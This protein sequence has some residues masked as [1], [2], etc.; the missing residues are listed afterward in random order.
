MKF[1]YFGEGKFGK[2]VGTLLLI[3]F[4]AVASVYV[5]TTLMAG[6]GTT[7]DPEDTPEY[8]MTDLA[9]V[10]VL[11]FDW[12]S[13]ALT[14]TELYVYETTGAPDFDDK[15]ESVK[16][17]FTHVTSDGDDGE[18]HFTS[19]TAKQYGWFVDESLTL[20]TGHFARTGTFTMSGL[21]KTSDRDVSEERSV[22]DR[23]FYVM[24]I[25]TWDWTNSTP[26]T[27]QTEASGKKYIEVLKNGTDVSSLCAP[28]YRSIIKVVLTQDCEA[29]G[30][31]E[32]DY[33]DIVFYDM[34]DNEIHLKHDE[35]IGYFLEIADYRSV[36]D[37]DS[38]TDAQWEDCLARDDNDDN[39]TGVMNFW[40]YLPDLG[41]SAYSNG[42][43]GNQVTITMTPVIMR[44]DADGDC[45]EVLTTSTA[46]HIQ[47]LVVNSAT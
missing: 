40:I 38:F 45:D 23:T 24:K 16:G 19:L 42:S 27:A 18:V 35:T 33:D 6:D 30:G 37:Y 41:S 4:F 34:L 47:L 9:G 26:E 15:I 32:I 29:S 13:T 28:G 36:T 3:S 17:S 5:Y 31:T 11:Q 10:G 44:N 2:I 7:P 25:G 1:D 8:W 14:S 20:G 22:T 46:G 12:T 21:I 39:V 43:A